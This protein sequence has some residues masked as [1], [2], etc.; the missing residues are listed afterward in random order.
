[1]LQEDKRIWNFADPSKLYAPDG[2]AATAS[3]AASNLRPMAL[4]CITDIGPC[5]VTDWA[6]SP[7][8]G[9]MA[10]IRCSQDAQMPVDFQDMSMK[11]SG[12]DWIV[13]SM[14][15]GHSPFLSRPIELAE[16]IMRFA[17]DFASD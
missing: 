13:H 11:Q 8:K 1:M 14:D 3:D 5:H 10:F 4:N 17:T 7:Y 6:A 2:P 16:V 15:A 12:G 9:H